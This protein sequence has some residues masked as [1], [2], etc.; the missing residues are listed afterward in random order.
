MQL[1]VGVDKSFDTPFIQIRVKSFF[2]LP[3]W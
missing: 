2:F 1:L 3:K